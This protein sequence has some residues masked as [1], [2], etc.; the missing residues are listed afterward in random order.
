[1]PISQ[2]KSTASALFEHIQTD[3]YRHLSLTSWHG[4]TV[5]N[6]AIADMLL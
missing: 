5:K 4:N 3:V 6:N 2:N 1:M